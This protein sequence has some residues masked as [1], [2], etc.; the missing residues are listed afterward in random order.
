MRK[1]RKRGPAA[2]R[3]SPRQPHY[4]RW[5]RKRQRKI[6]S[7]PKKTE[8][9]ILPICTVPYLARFCRK[10]SARAANAGRAAQGIRSQTVSHRENNPTKSTK[11]AFFATV[12]CFLMVISLF[13][14]TLT[15]SKYIFRGFSPIQNYEIIFPHAKD[16]FFFYGSK[17]LLPA[18]RLS[19]FFISRRGDG[20]PLLRRHGQKKRL[21]RQERSG[22][23]CF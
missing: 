10:N 18:L 16:E 21:W 9:R 15:A 8:P 3:Q 14:H 23:F 4:S 7:L 1:I 5:Q 22:F 20:L 2:K 11:S 19:F 13:L 12:F 17:Y 6:A